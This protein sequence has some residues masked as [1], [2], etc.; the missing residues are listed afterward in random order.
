MFESLDHIS[1]MALFD[2]GGVTPYQNRVVI[3]YITTSRFE[4]I[5]AKRRASN[6]WE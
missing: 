6:H 1:N 4:E 2:T 3:I 5:E